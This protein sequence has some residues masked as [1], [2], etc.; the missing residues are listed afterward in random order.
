MTSQSKEQDNMKKTYAPISGDVVLSAAEF[1]EIMAKAEA[2]TAEDKNKTYQKARYRPVASSEDETIPNG[3]EVVMLERNAS[4]GYLVTFN[5]PLCAEHSGTPIYINMDKLPTS[6]KIQRMTYAVLRHHL[7]CVIDAHV[8]ELKE[9]RRIK[10][11]VENTIV[12]TTANAK[13]TNLASPANSA[14]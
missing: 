1:K 8:A 3:V 2:Q 14:L 6:S 7:D 13:R 5:K 4:G 11:L 9:A 10:S 12:N